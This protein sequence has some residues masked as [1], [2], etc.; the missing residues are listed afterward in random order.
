MYIENLEGFDGEGDLF[1]KFGVEIRDQATFVVSRRRWDQTIKRYDNEISAVRPLE[2]DVLYIPFSQ[3][4]FEITHVEHEQP[5]YQLTNLPTYKLRC[6]LFEFSSEE[7]DTNV[8]EIDAIEGDNKFEEFFVGINDSG[9]AD[10]VIGNN[11][12]Q[13]LSNGTTLTAEIVSYNDSDNTIGI[14]HLR[15]SD[16]QF[17]EF[18][19][20]LTITSTTSTGTTLTRTVSNFFNTFETPTNRYYKSLTDFIDF[21]ES[22]P[23]GDL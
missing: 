7:F 20:N 8:T 12:I 13:T 10:Y 9:N 18:S 2:G 6:E 22:N 19:K 15:A 11:I 21:T 3:K 4:L 23:F 16:N 1:S 5:F 14:A 17:H